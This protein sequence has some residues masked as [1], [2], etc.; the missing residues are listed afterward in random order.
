MESAPTEFFHHVL[1]PSHDSTL[2]N[3]LSKRGFASFE[4]YFFNC[5][6][7]SSIF[8]LSKSFHFLF[9]GMYFS[10]IIPPYGTSFVMEFNT[11]STYP[12]VIFCSGHSFKKLN[13]HQYYRS[14][15]EQIYPVLYTYR[16]NP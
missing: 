4:L 8:S 14:Q 10:Y 6:L 3:S 9:P 11:I 13:N 2:I 12:L 5:S 7:P 15:G 16:S 1:S